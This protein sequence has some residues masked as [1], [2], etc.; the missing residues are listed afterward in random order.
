MP[1]DIGIRAVPGSDTVIRAVEVRDKPI[2]N[3]DIEILIDA[4]QRHAVNKIAMLAVS[5][6]QQTIDA[7]ESE[8]WGLA[9][10]IWFRL[11]IGWDDLLIEALYWSP[12]PVVPLRLA[13]ELILSRLEYYEVTAEGIDLWKQ[14]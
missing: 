6:S 3:K 11:F 8:R 14:I 12:P 13:Y 9:R 2:T 5:E 1:G 7:E 4:A 10:N